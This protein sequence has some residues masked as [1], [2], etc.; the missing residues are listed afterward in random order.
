MTY[1][2]ALFLLK[3]F[4]QNV[5]DDI[6][7]CSFS[8][9]SVLPGDSN[10]SS[11]I[12]IHNEVT[13]NFE[14]YPNDPALVNSSEI[15]SEYL[16][17]MI[18]IGPCQ[19]LASNIPGKSFPKRKQNNIF[20]SFHDTYY[21]K[22]LPDK[23]TVKRTWVSYSPSID[24][25]YCIVC[26]L[27]GTTKGKTN[28]LSREGTNDWQH[29]STRLNEHESSIDHLNSVIRYSMYVKNNRVD[30][31]DL[32]LTSNTKVAENRETVKV[33]IEIIIYL[34]RQN[35]PFRGHD[36]SV[37]SLNRGN[38]L[39]LV[40]LLS[41]HHPILSHHM[42]KIDNSIK[43]NR[44]TFLSNVSQ[45]T[46]IHILGEIVRKNI[47][48]SVAK[49]GKFSVIIDTTTNV[50]C[51]EQFSMI[52][53]FVDESGHIKER[54]VALE[55]VDDSSGRGM[56]NLFCNICSTYGLNW[57][58]NLIAQ[59]YD[60]AASMQGQYSGVR[61]LV[62]Q[63]NPRAIYVWCFSHVLNLVVVDT[64]DSC[65]ETRN[66]FGNI[67]SLKEFMR[68][69]KRTAL[70]LE[71][72]KKFFP[73]KRPLRMKT[74][75]TTRWTSHHRSLFV[76]FEKFKAIVA[77]LEDFS[78]SIDRLCSSTANNL[79]KNITSFSFVTVMFLM[80][81][82]F[83]ITTPLST[84]LQTPSN[85]YIQ[86]LT[87]VDIADQRLSKLRTQ[88]SVDTILQ[89]S[90]KFSVKNELDEIEFP[91]IR[92]R[93]RKRM[94]DENNSD[95]IT[96]SP[97]DYFRTNVY[98]L[99]IDKIKVSLTVRFKDARNIMKD[100]SFLS[101]ERLM[102][103]SNGDV[104]P[105]DTFDSLKTWIPEIDKD[106]I[107]MEYRNFA[108]SFQ[109][110]QSGICPEQLHDEDV[111]ISENTSDEDDSI[112]NSEMDDEDIVHNSS[113]KMLSPTQI[114]ELLNSFKL[115]SAFPNLYI[116]YKSLCT[117]PASSVSS[118]RSFSKVKLVKTRLRSTIG[119]GRLEGLLLL[120]C[121][122]DLSDKIN[123]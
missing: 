107:G 73:D 31:N 74:F 65:K 30:V 51:L 22:M 96:N 123:I 5:V 75:S 76:I 15:T 98:F 32:R 117:I 16:S 12:S 114:F 78:E 60:G 82:I 116:A 89:E 44:L 18:S 17:Y 103:V 92:Q 40:K 1:L 84:Y 42:A 10:G 58:S 49:A 110:L 80:N 97:V 63:Q 28:S 3:V 122:K 59:S 94:D 29:I 119:Q 71:Y 26:K 45:N 34:A 25:V 46:L 90:K 37:N 68:A 86:A 87:M 95:E 8:T 121:E 41:H 21:Y 48:T 24:R 112:I 57:K 100:L 101:Y 115:A 14:R 88:E 72:Q 113:K 77:T 66:F 111:L 83:D 62:Q 2:L 39:Q 79:L 50:A 93:K 13:S 11:I 118:E 35:I 64:C 47:F 19:P 120:S 33:I 67:Q 52:L 36:E 104:V 109:K 38:F 20:R 6:S 102:K 56:F 85:D 55:V 43:K 108:M 105:K 99:C 27:F 23:S 106:S 61:T 54:L 91:K 53:R 81:K 7:S 4:Y 9:E 69:R 70:F